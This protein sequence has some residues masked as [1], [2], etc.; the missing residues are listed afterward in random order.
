MR[1]LVLSPFGET[2]PYGEENLKTVARADV[3]FSFESLKEVFPLPYNTYRYNVLKCTDAAVE[4]IVKAE[5]EGYDAVVLS[6]MYD[7]GLFEAREVVDIPVMGTLEASG[8]VCMMMGQMFSIVCP[9]QVVTSVLRRT[10]D[11]YGFTPRCASLRHI[12]VVA[13][14]LYPDR[15]P[16]DE[17]MRRLVE[18]GRK[19][20]EDGAEILIPGCS[21]IGALYTKAFGRDPVEVIG[22]PVLDPQLVAF[23]MAE[24]M[25][26]LRVKAGYPAVSRIGMWKKQPRQEFLYLRE[27]LASHK[28]ALNYYHRELGAKEEPGKA[29]QV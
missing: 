14:D 9:E 16:T 27:W 18:V 4:R 3:E 11:A 19:C 28:P 26:D 20:V 7:P 6:C 24:M 15:T 29:K 22:V 5:R 13:C 23:K 1:I 8:L 21:I 25:V 2:E 10:I 12:D 17:I